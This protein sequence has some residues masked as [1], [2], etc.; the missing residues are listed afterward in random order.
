M[1][2]TYIGL[3]RFGFS[4][5]FGVALT[6]CFAGIERTRKNNLAVGCICV[7]LLLAQSFCWWLFGIDLTSKIYPLIIHLPVILFLTIYMKRPWLIS[8][9][10]VLSAYLC[11]Q[12][13]RLIGSI[14]GAVFGSRLG[15]HICYIAVVFLAY[16]LF[17]R[18]VAGTL[19]QL[20]D[21]STKSCILLG[22]VPLFYYLFDFTTI[23]TD[24]LYQGV[25]GVVQFI[26]SV[27]SIVY[28]VFIILYYAEMQKQVLAHRERDMLAA[29]LHSAHSELVSLRQMQ[30]TAAAY[31]HDMRHHF[32]ILQ[33]MASEGGIEK[34][35]TYLNIA[36]SDIDAITPIRFCENE[37][38]NLILSTFFTKAKHAGIT[39]KVDVKLPSSIPLSD[40]E[41]CS[42]LS[43]GLENAIFAAARL[44]SERRVVS[45]K[46]MVHKSNL[47][48]LIENPYVG[49]IVMKSGLP[50]SS[51]EGHGYGTH[52]IAAIADA[53]GGQAIFSAEEG[54]F[55]LKIILSLRKLDT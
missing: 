24:L 10:S 21:K 7:I 55:T 13:P 25:N 42:L 53:H 52:I 54:V 27:F 36:Q 16:Y 37:T 47:L 51:L 22:A 29:Q 8:I 14:G 9:V 3:I 17:Q 43:N 31:R 19:R 28:F 23:S 48:I 30:N 12:A 20:M 33:G 38:V 44:D 26:S 49:E 2:T 5:L 32:A 35:K 6:V 45:F 4:L 1:I 39:M 34:I 41:L 11:C 15:E 18:Y 46:A 50:Q 40:T